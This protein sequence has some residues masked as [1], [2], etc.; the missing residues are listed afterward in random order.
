MKKS[1]V[2]SILMVCFCSSYAQ[3][4]RLVFSGYVK[5]LL[6]YY[7]PENKI[8][9][10]D[11]DD[12]YSN[13]IHNRLNLRWYASEQLTFAVEARNRMFFGSV[14]S[15]IP[16]YKS[17]IDFDP[18]HFDLAAIV[19]SGDSW[20]LHT[21]LDRAWMEYAGNKMQV[22]IGRQRIN[23][24]MNLIWNPN[25]IFNTFSFFDFDYEERPGSDAIRLKYFTGAT[26]SAEFAFKSG[27]TPKENTFAGLYRFY[28]LEL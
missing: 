9:G 3:D 26:S 1:W 25:D 10:I 7:Q 5:E 18:G 8:S 24:G 12:F 2:L 21:M 6:F 14:I 16:Y 13:T 27:H 15:D 28:G 20:F 11:K 19:S 23:W 22:I 17:T 4:S